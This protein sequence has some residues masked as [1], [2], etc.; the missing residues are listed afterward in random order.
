MKNADKKIKTNSNINLFESK[1]I[2]N[3]IKSKKEIKSLNSFNPY[4]KNYLFYSLILI[5]IIFTCNIRGT[6]NIRT[7][8]MRISFISLKIKGPGFRN[9]FSSNVRAPPTEIDINGYFMRYNG[10]YRLYLNQSDNEIKLYF[11]GYDITTCNYLFMG[12]SSIYEMDL[13]NFDASKV[14]AMTLMFYQCTSLVSINLNNLVTPR[15]KNMKNM[16]VLCKSL[17]SLNFSNFNTSLVS[18]M[19]STFYGLESLVS[20]DLSQNDLSNVQTM[21]GAFYNCTNLRYLKLPNT[22]LP[23][24]HKFKIFKITK[25]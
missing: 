13:S 11:S 15:L 5:Y 4:H 7:I 19:E 12:C 22:N 18:D 6:N 20:L 1:E 21:Y 25:Y 16:F 10:S 24:L 14:A 9:V 3:T 17:V 23:K 8:Q 2:Q